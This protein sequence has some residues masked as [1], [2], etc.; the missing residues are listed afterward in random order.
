MTTYAPAFSTSDTI[1]DIVAK[2]P[3]TIRVFH[4]F[5]LDACCGGTLPLATAAQHHGLDVQEVL[6]ALVAVQQAQER[7]R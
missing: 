7:E 5:G 6:A 4:Q 2:Q 1:N 3:E